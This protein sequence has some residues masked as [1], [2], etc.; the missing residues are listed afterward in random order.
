MAGWNNDRV[1]VRWIRELNE[2]R[3]NERRTIHDDHGRL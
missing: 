3:E 2:N 1:Y